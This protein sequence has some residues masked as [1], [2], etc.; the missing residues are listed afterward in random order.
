MSLQRLGAETL[1]PGYY[2]WLSTMTPANPHPENRPVL[3]LGQSRCTGG[4]FPKEETLVLLKPGGW[5]GSKADV[6]AMTPAT[7]ETDT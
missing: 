7:L 1:S 2:T 4:N 5:S 6:L 3:I